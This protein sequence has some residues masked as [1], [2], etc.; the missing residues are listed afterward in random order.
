ML[1]R[2]PIITVNATS[3]LLQFFSSVLALLCTH[4]LHY[5]LDS[6]KIDIDTLMDV[7]LRC[8]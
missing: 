6:N 7:T 3:D 8:E 5:K 4:L 2:E 1:I